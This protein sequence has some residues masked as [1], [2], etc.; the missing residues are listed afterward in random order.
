[1]TYLLCIVSFAVW[2]LS[3]RLDCKSMEIKWYKHMKVGV[4][5]KIKGETNA[6]LKQGDTLV[7][8]GDMQ[9]ANSRLHVYIASFFS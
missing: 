5:N 7:K 2:E 4:S 3:G 1:M 9:G 8:Q 6:W